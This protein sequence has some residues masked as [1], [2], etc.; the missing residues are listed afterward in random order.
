MHVIGSNHF[1]TM[2][3]FTEC[4]IFNTSHYNLRHL[5]MISEPDFWT[6]IACFQM[7]LTQNRK[8]GG[9]K[10]LEWNKAVYGSIHP[11]HN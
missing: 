6:E 10:S 5:V 7:V 1:I 9:K 4:T 8:F 2:I 11:I 3:I